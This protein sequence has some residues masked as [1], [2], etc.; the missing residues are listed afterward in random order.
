MLTGAGEIITASPTGEHADLFFGFPNS[1]GTLGY[2]TR[3]RVR[4]EPIKPFVALRHL[5][6]GRLQDLQDA[7]EHDRRQLDP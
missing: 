1:Y 4:L 3:L 6:F 2:A 7:I 5:R